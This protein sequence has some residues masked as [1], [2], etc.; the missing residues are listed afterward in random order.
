MV[1]IKIE[2]IN[3]ELLQDIYLGQISVGEAKTLK[4]VMEDKRKI[5]MILLGICAA[6]CV[7]SIALFLLHDVF[8]F[9]DGVMICL[10]CG[11]M[12]PIIFGPLAGNGLSIAMIYLS[13]LRKSEPG[14]A[15]YAI[16]EALNLNKTDKALLERI[17]SH[18]YSTAHAKGILHMAEAV[19]LTHIRYTIF[20]SI[21]TMAAAVLALFAPS[22]I[23][24]LEGESESFLR[25]LM[26][27]ARWLPV[28]MASGAVSNILRAR[29]PKKYIDAIHASYSDER[30][31]E[32]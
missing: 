8:L 22:L 30:A 15:E 23:M 18:H 28:L 1:I 29:V 13:A 10:I 4:A 3:E 5:G 21:M 9:N 26:L 6:V 19:R 25:N 24:S 16:K 14:T 27:A 17:S 11:I 32:W 31:N 2:R 12:S 7:C 20:S